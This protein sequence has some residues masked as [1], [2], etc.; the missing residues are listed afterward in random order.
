MAINNSVTVDIKARADQAS[1]KEVRKLFE[2][3][4]GDLETQKSN[5]IKMPGG[6][7]AKEIK[8]EIDCLSKVDKSK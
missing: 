3:T 5:A 4:I 6:G 7:R 2:Q 8:E 1:F